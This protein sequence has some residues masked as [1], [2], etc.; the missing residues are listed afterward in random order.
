MIYRMRGWTMI[1]S[2]II[3]VHPLIILITVQT[4]RVAKLR[5]ATVA[6][7]EEERRGASGRRTQETLGIENQ[8]GREID[9]RGPACREDE[10]LRR[11]RHSRGSQR[12]PILQS[13]DRPFAL[14]Q[15]ALRS[16]AGR[17]RATTTHRT[18]SGR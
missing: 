15:H 13:R 14:A 11:K 17:R 16:R 5:R 1:T 18:G 2:R 12:Q 8:G 7:L 6:N 3:I 4:V 9:L 10:R